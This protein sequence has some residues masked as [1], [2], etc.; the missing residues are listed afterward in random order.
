MDAMLIDRELLLKFVEWYSTLGYLDMMEIIQENLDKLAVFGYEF[1]GYMRAIDNAADYM[2]ASMDLLEP[3]VMQELFLGER[4]ISTKIQ[5]APPVKYF[6][7]CQVHNSIIA[8][9]CMIRGTVENSI[10]FR[11]C[12]VEEGAVVRNSIIMPNDVIS[13]GAQLENVICDKFVTIGEGVR[14]YGSALRP[15][16]VTKKQYS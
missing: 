5:D 6:P 14:L 9:G 15:L 3:Q 13:K 8:T 7:G 11:S 16:I 4:H 10:I 12:T 1:K 2:A